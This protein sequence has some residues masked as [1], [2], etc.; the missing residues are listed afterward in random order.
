MS[1][2]RYNANLPIIALKT[3]DAPDDNITVT[4]LLFCIHVYWLET[5]YKE[6]WG[7]YFILDKV[8]LRLARIIGGG[9]TSCVWFSSVK[10]IGAMETAEAVTH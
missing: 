9:C 10:S 7:L 6:S 5:E 8:G 2:R 1:I 3:T 4:H